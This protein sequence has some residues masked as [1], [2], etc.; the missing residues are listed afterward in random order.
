MTLRIRDQSA[1]LHLDFLLANVKDVLAHEEVKGQLV[2][3]DCLDK[4]YLHNDDFITEY[5]EWVDVGYLDRG[6]S[7]TRY[8]TDAKEDYGEQEPLLLRLERVTH[9]RDRFESAEEKESTYCHDRQ[10]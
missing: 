3:Q 10:R 4:L 5:F 6:L 1:L 9:V 8:E 2:A 7:D